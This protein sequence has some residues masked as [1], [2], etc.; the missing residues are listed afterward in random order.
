M[1]T[2]DRV[3]M[4]PLDENKEQGE[5]KIAEEVLTLIAWMAARDVPGVYDA[6][7][8]DRRDFVGRLTRGGTSRGVTIHL[9]D[10]TAFFEVAMVG[11]YGYDLVSVARAVQQAIKEAVESMTSIHVERVDITV[12]DVRPS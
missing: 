6:H 8:D 12:V 1:E 9:E 10:G 4:P 7:E 11:V 2:Q 3:R 5:I